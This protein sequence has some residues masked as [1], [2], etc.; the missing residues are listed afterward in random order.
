MV[1]GLFAVL[2]G[3]RTTKPAHD[4]GISTSGGFVEVHVPGDHTRVGVVFLHSLNHT[5]HEATVL[6]WS[7]VSDAYGFVGIYPD[8]VGEAWNAGLCCSDAA[9]TNRDDVGWLKGVIADM[10][11]RYGLTTIYLAGFSN[12][13]MMV[14]RLVAEDPSITDRFAV[15]GAAPEMPTAGHWSGKGF[16]YDGGNDTTVPWRGG[17]STI[18]GKTYLI[19]P[20]QATGSWLIGADLSGHLVPGYGHSP[21]PGWALLAWH[22]LSS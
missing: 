18:L 17:V 8:R 1:F 7:S 16:I 12:G 11:T 3:C 2:G 14:E 20:A 15:W 19:R 4:D 5:W 13:G 10:K 6:G 22:Q 21:E 9:A